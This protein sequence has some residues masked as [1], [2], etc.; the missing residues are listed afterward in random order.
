MTNAATA[1]IN[2]AITLHAIEII[3]APIFAAAN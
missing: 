2:G 1:R 3:V